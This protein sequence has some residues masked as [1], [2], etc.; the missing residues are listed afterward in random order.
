MTDISNV[1]RHGSFGESHIEERPVTYDNHVKKGDA[2]TG[3]NEAHNWG[4]DPDH[5][6]IAHPV[7]GDNFSKKP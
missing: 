7:K 6:H 4:T 2:K 5:T 3:T 1:V